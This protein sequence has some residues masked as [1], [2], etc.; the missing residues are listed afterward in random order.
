M[1]VPQDALQDSVEYLRVIRILECACDECDRSTQGEHGS[2]SDL[3]HATSTG[4]GG[5]SHRARV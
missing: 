5:R 3:R 1:N 4:A 2:T